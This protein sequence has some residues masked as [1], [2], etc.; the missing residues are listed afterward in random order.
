MRPR[1][2]LP[3]WAL[4]AGG[5]AAAGAAAI[6][7]NNPPAGDEAFVIGYAFGSGL[8]PVL[9]GLLISWVVFRFGEPNRTVAGV[10]FTA[11]A[12]LGVATSAIG[13]DREREQRVAEERAAEE[14]AAE[15]EALRVE[16]LEQL[17]AGEMSAVEGRVRRIIA[18]M[19]RAADQTSGDDREFLDLVIST[20]GDLIPVCRRYDRAWDAYDA[21][22]GLDPS[23]FET[24]AD[25]DA[26]IAIAE[27]TIRRSIALRDGFRGAPGRIRQR[28][29]RSD[30]DSSVAEG[31]LAATSG[32]GRQLEI[33]AKVNDLDVKAATANRDLLKLLRDEYGRWSLADDIIEFDD[34]DVSDRYN[35][36]V[37]QLEHYGAEQEAAMRSLLEQ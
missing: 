32:S 27:E 17:D 14:L 31:F 23:G 34:T 28:V 2:S 30:L 4:L 24:V 7:W 20:Y 19:Q 29:R 5:L 6:A 26:R 3:W 18:V 1:F 13:L 12:L 11:M 8:G 15:T 36:L 22:G 21:A 33:Q 25:V 9:V 37:D 35:A 10:V 16:Q